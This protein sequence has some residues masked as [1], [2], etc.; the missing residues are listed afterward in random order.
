MEFKEGELVRLK[1]G[2]PLM[3]V[4]EAHEHDLS[5]IWFE[6]VGNKQV[7]QRNSFPPVVLE[8]GQKP[9]PGIASIRIGR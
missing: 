2:G 9:G 3:T 4:E 8:K 6:K 7:L 5:C 1:S